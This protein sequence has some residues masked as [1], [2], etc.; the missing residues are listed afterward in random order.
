MK[1]TVLQLKHMHC[2]PTGTIIGL[3]IFMSFV[4]TLEK[5]DCISFIW[6]S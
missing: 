1:V 4:S 5:C 6:Q 3:G 2:F